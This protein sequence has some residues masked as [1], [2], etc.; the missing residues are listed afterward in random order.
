MIARPSLGDGRAVKSL[1]GRDNSGQK[2][3]LWEEDVATE[4]TTP[5][6]ELITKRGAK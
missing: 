5:S 4:Y 6:L 3:G 1:L 2:E